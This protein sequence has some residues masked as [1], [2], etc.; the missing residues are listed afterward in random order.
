MHVAS[1]KGVDH[2]RC[3]CF[4]QCSC[5]IVCEQI[6]ACHLV[7]VAF[8]DPSTLGAGSHLDWS[9]GV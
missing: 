1:E 7:S 6:V 2:R 3:S 8:A 9:A 5:H 4:L